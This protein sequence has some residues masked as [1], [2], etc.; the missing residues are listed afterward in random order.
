MGSSNVH[1]RQ[2]VQ[3]DIAAGMELV[4]LAGWNQTEADWQRFLDAGAEGCF[5][6]SI[7]HEVCG[8][9]VT[10]NYGNQLAWVGMVLVSPNHRGQGIGTNLLECALAHLD[11]YG[12]LTIKLDATPQGRPIYERLGFEAN[13][14]LER[15]ALESAL[16]SPASRAFRS[17]DE[18]EF[19]VESIAALDR[20]VFDADRRGLLRSLHRDAP[21]LTFAI[22]NEG[23]LEGFSLGRHGL[24]SDHLGPWIARNEIAAA[25]LLDRFLHFSTR[26][27]LIVDCVKSN[28]SANRLL[29]A[30]GFRFS[31]P[32]T[33]MV[34]G[35]NHRSEPSEL[36]YA[37]L[38]PEFG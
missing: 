22:W 8:T 4:R 5:V 16:S 27:R 17:R 33:R 11:S 21:E 15:W 30:A 36:L 28:P 9:V 25:K 7:D 13:Y 37:I 14:E 6:A 23:T 1:I 3:D 18:S 20:G 26:D 34:R 2:M 12:P 24:H 32:L 19:R 38:G 10:I 31:R 29:L 35:L